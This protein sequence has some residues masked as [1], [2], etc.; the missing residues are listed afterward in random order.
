MLIH[1]KN[2]Y[3]SYNFKRQKINV[4]NDVNMMVEKGDRVAIMG[5]SGS[6]KTTLLNIIG[7]LDF[8][9]SGQYWF[10]EKLISFKSQ[11]EISEFR[12]KKI[13]FIPQGFS[14]ID[15]KS[16]YFNIALPLKFRNYSKNDIER[17]VLSVA[18][19][20]EI[21]KL[22]DKSPRQLSVGECQRVAIARAIITSPILILAD[23]PTSSLDKETEMVILKLFDKLQ[24]EGTTIITVTHD[25]EVASK[26]RRVL[27]LVNGVVKNFSIN[28]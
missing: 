20:L 13:G 9:D 6:G 22:L 17:R 18:H 3:K 11:S 2:I 21:N 27:T 26:C 24:S 4:L 7:G 19:E 14:L 12:R 23:E 25:F 1:L 16:T 5:K 15:Y 28:S 10:E 8:P